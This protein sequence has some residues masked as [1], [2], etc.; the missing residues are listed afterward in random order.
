M[1]VG[2]WLRPVLWT[3]LPKASIDK[4]KEA[5]ACK[6]DVRAHSNCACDYRVIDAITEALPMK[7]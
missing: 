2:G 3:R 4:D 5:I 7:L 1:L 6:D